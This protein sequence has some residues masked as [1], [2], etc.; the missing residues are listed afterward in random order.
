MAYSLSR[1]RSK[2]PVSVDISRPSIESSLTAEAA[3]EA[4]VP[5]Q[6]AEVTTKGGTSWTTSA[7][8][9]GTFKVK[10]AVSDTVDS[11]MLSVAA[12]S[13]HTHELPRFS[14]E[15]LCLSDRVLSLLCL[16]VL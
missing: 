11:G 1:T 3:E 14:A 13:N 10:D 5:T 16:C 9:W 12:R 4:Q 7:T 8:P 6:T 2:R 15:H